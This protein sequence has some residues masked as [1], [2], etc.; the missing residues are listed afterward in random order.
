MA[1]K[2]GRQ[3]SNSQPS[4]E[5]VCRLSKWGGPKHIGR[6]RAGLWALQAIF[7]PVFGL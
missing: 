4:L 3:K 5:N 2:A 7:S 1:I 6:I